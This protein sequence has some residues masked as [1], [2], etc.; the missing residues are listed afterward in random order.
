MPALVTGL[1]LLWPVTARGQGE[2]ADFSKRLAEYS[3]SNNG[4]AERSTAVRACAGLAGHDEDKGKKAALRDQ[5]KGAL[6]ETLRK[7]FP[8]KLKAAREKLAKDPNDAD[9]KDTL[10]ALEGLVAAAL[11]S[12]KTA[13]GKEEY[14]DLGATVRPY[15]AD[16]SDKIWGPALAVMRDTPGARGLKDELLGALASNRRDLG[17]LERALIPAVRGLPADEALDVLGAIVKSRAGLDAVIACDEIGDMV[18]RRP[19]RQVNQKKVQTI[20]AEPL[21]SGQANVSNAAALALWRHNSWD[22]IPTVFERIEGKNATDD[23]WAVICQVGCR[24]GGWNGVA[25]NMLMSSAPDA[26][27]DAVK[28]ARAWFDSVKSKAPEAALQDALAAAKIQARGG[29]ESKEGISALIEGMD[30]ADRAL[31]YAC[32]DVFVKKTQSF[33]FASK[34]KALLTGDP[35]RNKS[36]STFEDEPRYGFADAGKNEK[37]KAQQSDSVAKVRA[38]WAK[39]GDKA[40]FSGGVCSEKYEPEAGKAPTSH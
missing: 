15:V 2:P 6:D 24:A 32:L 4:A 21:K 28:S 10:K 25:Q 26:R 39:V 19:I 37:L 12:I 16:S 30:N 18:L 20:L 1:L 7:E 9:A 5:L 36:V 31:R 40:S 11:S 3:N 17:T 29:F 38:W 8:A 22:G 23:D 14:P 27:A 33:T 34:F 13:W 35:T